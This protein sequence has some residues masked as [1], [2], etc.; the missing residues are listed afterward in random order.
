MSDGSFGIEMID[1]ASPAERRKIYCAAWEVQHALGTTLAQSSNDVAG[2]FYRGGL[3][4]M[5]RRAV[6]GGY[7][8]QLPDMPPDYR[9]EERGELRKLLRSATDAIGHMRRTAGHAPH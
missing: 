8:G 9:P 6:L 7:D 5:R 3:Q 1:A 2:V 4:A